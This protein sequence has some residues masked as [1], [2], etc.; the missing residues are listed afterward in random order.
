MAGRD[1]IAIAKGLGKIFRAGCTCS[2]SKPQS[3]SALGT[4]LCTVYCKNGYKNGEGNNTSNYQ[5]LASFEDSSDGNSSPGN[6]V[7]GPAPPQWR[8]G[9][10]PGTSRRVHTWCYRRYHVSAC[11]KTMSDTVVRDSGLSRSEDKGKEQRV[12]EGGCAHHMVVFLVGIGSVLGCSCSLR[13]KLKKRPYLQADLEGQSVLEVIRA[14]CA[15]YLVQL[16]SLFL[17]LLVQV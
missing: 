3:S 15:F 9:D 1:L 14:C 8:K 17:F 4:S 11:L 12:S 16:S 6:G 2:C 10:L 13:L 7:T 5:E